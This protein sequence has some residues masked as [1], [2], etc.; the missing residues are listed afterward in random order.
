MQMKNCDMC[1]SAGS[2][3]KWG[4][5]EICGSEAKKQ[6]STVGWSS[7][8]IRSRSRSDKASA[9]KKAAVASKAGTS[10]F[11]KDAA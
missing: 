6:G 1:L 2:V 11:G 8:A 3:N 10:H 4:V 7:L 5:C 9:S